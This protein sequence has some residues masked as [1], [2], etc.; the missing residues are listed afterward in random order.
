[1]SISPPTRVFIPAIK[2]LP[3]CLDWTTL[4]LA[5]PR[6]WISLPGM[7]SIFRSSI[8]FSS[9]DLFDALDEGQQDPDD[10]HSR[11]EGEYHHH[12]QRGCV[13]GEGH[14]SPHQQGHDAPH[15]DHEQ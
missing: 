8:F 6:A 5:I 14:G 9:L 12:R 15:Q 4:P 1:L 2:S 10:E 7:Y 11:D 3:K 13:G